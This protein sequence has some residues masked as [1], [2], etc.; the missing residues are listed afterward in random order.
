MARALVVFESMWG[1]SEEVAKAVATGVGE[2]MPV[3]VVPVA[4]APTE[5]ADVDLV[6]AGGPTHAFS[7]SRTSTRRD[8]REQGATRGSVETGMREWLSALPDEHRRWFAA[9]DTRVTR[10]KRLPGSA[11]R[12]A[13]R[14]GR[15]H[16]FQQATDPESFYVLDVEG[17]LDEGELDRARKWGHS[18]AASVPALA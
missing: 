10:V 18:V 7:M 14:L 11:A 1:N 6:L 8:A 4:E 16:G 3:D 12:S 2:V 13:T 9:F 15:R 17:P 5:L